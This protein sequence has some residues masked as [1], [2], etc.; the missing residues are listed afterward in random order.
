[1]NIEELAVFNDEAHHTHDEES[2]WNECIRRLHAEVPSGVGGQFDPKCAEAF[3]RLRPSIEQL[4]QQHRSQTHTD[5]LGK[6]FEVAKLL[7][8]PLCA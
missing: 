3:L 5:N 1:M 4:I 6:I 2:Q 7:A 8:S